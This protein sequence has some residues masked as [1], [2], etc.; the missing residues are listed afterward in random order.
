MCVMVSLSLFNLKVSGPCLFKRPKRRRTQKAV[1]V[2]YAQRHVQQFCYWLYFMAS[3][4]CTCVVP[5]RGIRIVRGKPRK[6]PR[7][8]L[9]RLFVWSKVLFYW[10]R[11]AGIFITRC[12]I[13]KPRVRLLFSLW[14]WVSC[15]S[16][17]LFWC[18]QHTKNLSKFEHEL[19]S[20]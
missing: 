9:V 17:R 15:V 6:R 20:I 3:K 1:A 8:T 2:P 14:R 4:Y 16:Q 18:A 13:S 11:I 12:V 7:K 19:G 5:D 10:I